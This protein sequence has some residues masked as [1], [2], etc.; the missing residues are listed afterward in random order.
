MLSE[1]LEALVTHVEM[2]NVPIPRR[3]DGWILL[4]GVGDPLSNL[5]P[6]GSPIWDGG[7]DLH[8]VVVNLSRVQRPGNGEEEER[9]TDTQRHPVVLQ[10]E[11]LWVAYNR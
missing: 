7:P 6:L 4:D 10:R 8:R 11:I 9:F 2:I 5:A 1:V 3:L